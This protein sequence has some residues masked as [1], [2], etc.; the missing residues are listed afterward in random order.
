MRRNVPQT[1]CYCRLGAV[2]WISWSV[3]WGSLNTKSRLSQQMC[4]S[5][6]SAQSHPCLCRLLQKRAPGKVF[7]HKIFRTK[8]FV[9]NSHLDRMVLKSARGWQN[10]SWKN[11]WTP[12]KLW[13]QV[14]SLFPGWRSD[15][16]PESQGWGKVWGSRD[17]S[18]PHA[19][20]QDHL[21]VSIRCCLP[22]AAGPAPLCGVSLAPSICSMDWFAM[23]GKQIALVS[24]PRTNR[25]G[26]FCCPLTKS[27]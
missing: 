18:L 21:D 12:L 14:C 15:Q 7:K 17:F 26:E 22:L 8:Q 1:L 2:L 4:R 20:V 6:G 3:A 23:L 13:R 10:S 25:W 5:A 27:S 19:L 11:S 24:Q 9:P 16:H